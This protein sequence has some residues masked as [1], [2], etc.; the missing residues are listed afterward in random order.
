VVINWAYKLVFLELKKDW[1]YLQQ[2]VAALFIIWAVKFFEYWPEKDE[3][4]SH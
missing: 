4:L 1:L 2:Y 3:Y